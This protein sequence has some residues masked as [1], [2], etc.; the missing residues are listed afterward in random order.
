MEFICG[1]KINY[2]YENDFQKILIEKCVF[3]GVIFEDMG[4]HIDAQMPCCLRLCVHSI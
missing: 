4:V 1:K 3:L 2:T